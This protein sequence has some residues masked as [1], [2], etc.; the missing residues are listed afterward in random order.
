MISLLLVDIA[1]VHTGYLTY[2][3]ISVKRKHDKATIKRKHFNYWELLTVSEGES[4]TL[5]EGDIVQ[6][7]RQAWGSGNN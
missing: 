5:M 3:Y 7:S 1:V 4:M 2:F 6:A